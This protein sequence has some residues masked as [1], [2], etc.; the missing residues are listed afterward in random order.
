MTRLERTTFHTS[1]AAEYFYARELEAQTGQSQSRFRMVALKELVD[2]ALDSAEG[3]GRTPEVAVDVELDGS[4]HLTVKDNGAGV[5]PHVVEQTLDFN[6]RTSDKALYRTPTRGQQG[7]AL[8]TIV[9]MPFAMGDDDPEVVVQGRGV[10]HRIRA[11]LGAG[12]FPDILR[13]PEDA[14]D[15]AGTLVEVRL[16]GRLHGTGDL[17]QAQRMIRGYH[18]FNPHAKVSFRGF[19]SGVNHGESAKPEVAET[20]HPTNRDYDKFDAGSLLVVHWFSEGDFVRLVKHLVGHGKG[21]TAIGTFLK[22]FRGF[23]ARAK[24]AGVRRELPAGRGTLAD[25]SDEDIAVLYRAMCKAVKEPSH[26]VLGSP[27]GEAHL[28][29]ALRRFHEEPDVRPGR[30]WHKVF[31]TTL[32]GAPAIVE[33]AVLEANVGDLYVGLNHSPTYSDPLA[34]TYLVHSNSKG[35]I[36][37]F[38]IRGF[39]QDA[40][41]MGHFGSAAVAVHITAAAPTTLDRGKTRL[42]VDD[43][44]FE[45]AVEKA[46]WSV[47]KELYEEAK[48]RE[49]DAAAAEREH[50]RALKRWDQKTK[51]ITKADACYRVM[52]EAYLY[53]TGN[54]SLPTMARDLYYAVR[55][56]IESF[57]YDADELG[58]N[59]FSQ[60]ILPDYR[61]EEQEL[62]L[63]NYDAR[64]TLHEPH[65]G[66]RIELGTRSVAEYNFP[67][68]VFDKVLYIEKKGRVE[69]L[70]AAGVDGRHDMAI[71]GGQGY[72]TE[73]VRTLFETAEEGNYQLFVLHDA[74]PHGYAIARTLREETERMPD[75][76][77]EVIDLGLHLQDALV[78]GKRPETFTRRNKIDEKVEAAL[79]GVELEHFVGDE[80]T[81][82]DGKKYWISKRV[83][84][85]DLSS[86]QLV[87][88]VERRLA[89]EGVRG[90]VV[91]PEDDLG[92]LT[93][94]M[95]QERVAS[96]TEAAI[97]RLLDTPAMKEMLAKRFRE[98]FAL[99]DARTY[100]EEGFEED[101]T[102]SWREALRGNLDQTHD[103]DS[104]GFDAAVM[105][106]IRDALGKTA[107]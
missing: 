32:N 48:K 11:V 24:A 2:N 77:V 15:G 90:K 100:I 3:D 28:V 60:T 43:P 94:K 70:Q 58:Y 71:I 80:H 78:L 89:E 9:A 92:D 17:L 54:E 69:I 1:R 59:Y 61:R 101:D 85:N 4:Y 25:L 19:V 83:E 27:L 104:K 93:D 18:L 67:D 82:K 30:A 99:Q 96:W 16:P 63:V 10:R 23:S 51:R 8:K 14:D 22:D 81:D 66:E 20:H 57:G 106:A 79:T 37:G 73:A 26:N 38:G 64:G 6:T 31:K 47:G 91:P 13:D 88:Y 95:Y 55:N 105:K 62:P 50:E 52:W 75:Y 68:Y 53:S 98:S 56:R 12:D 34:D 5:E 103:E 84:L 97:A 45:E 21:E 107:S 40:S 87:E 39:L 36:E 74:D 76:S 65:D 29:G 49:R 72:A 46:L 41:V 35:T 7:N 42:S 102:R 86:P 44:E 33:A